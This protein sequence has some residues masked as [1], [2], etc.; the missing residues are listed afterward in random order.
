M[1]KK[2]VI[3][4]TTPERAADLRQQSR[5]MDKLGLKYL[6]PEVEVHLG[7]AVPIDLEE[8]NWRTI[9]TENNWEDWKASE[10]LFARYKADPEGANTFEDY[11]E[12]PDN[13]E[14]FVLEQEKALADE[15]VEHI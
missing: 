13:R 5:Q 1:A 12:R 7:A 2:V 11:M 10:A 6:E 3:D 14:R 15:D 9:H 8:A 4:L